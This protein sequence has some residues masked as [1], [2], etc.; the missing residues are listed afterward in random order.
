MSTATVN[1]AAGTTSNIIA[2]TPQMSI[3]AGP[4]VLGGTTTLQYGATQSGPFYTWSFGASANPQSFRSATNAY[5]QVAAATQASNVAICDMGGQIGGTGGFLAS[6]NVPMASGSSTAEQIIGSLRLPPGMIPLNS[7]LRL[8][9][10]VSMLDGSDA[11]TLQVRVLGVA[12]TLTFQSLALASCA[13][14]NFDNEIL[15]AGD[16]VTIK[17]MGAGGG[18]A[19]LA[20]GWGGVTGVPYTSVATTNYQQ[21]EIEVVVTCT[22]GTA[23]S[24]MVLQGLT[25]QLIS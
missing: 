7:R 11:K 12:G 13:T 23:G 25:A 15:F 5:I 10:N 22:K 14:F 2:V 21:N 6:I 20:A 18:A 17:G 4:A 3:L 9:G 16:G 24:L 19:A 8:V 1:V